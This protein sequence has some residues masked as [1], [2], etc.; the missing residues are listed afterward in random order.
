MKRQ[1]AYYGACTDQLKLQFIGRFPSASSHCNDKLLTSCSTLRPQYPGDCPSSN[2][3]FPL[4]SVSCFV[5]AIPE[6][7]SPYDFRILPLGEPGELVVGGYQLASGYLNRPEQT[8]AAFIDTPYGPVYRTGDKATMKPDGTIECLG[9]ISDGQVKLRGQRIELGEVEQAAMRTEGCHSAIAMV[10]GGILVAFCAFDDDSKSEDQAEDVI[11]TCRKWLPS[12]MVPGNVVIKT[13]FPRLPSGKVDRKQLKSDYAISTTPTESHSTAHPETSNPLEREISA[14]VSDCLGFQVSLSA[15]LASSG[16]DSLKAIRLASALWERGFQTSATDVL[17]SKTLSALC[18]TLQAEKSSSTPSQEDAPIS[19]AD[20]A[21]IQISQVLEKH[22]HLALL[23][24]EIERLFWCTPLQNSMLAETSVNPQA[25]C[26]WIELEFPPDITTQ[27]IEKWTHQIAENNCILRSGFVSFGRGF[28]HVTFRQLSQSAIQTVDQFDHGFQLVSDEDYLRPLRVQ[29]RDGKQSKGP[30]ALFQLHHAIYDGWSVDMLVEDFSALA[31]GRSP[32]SRPQYQDVARF[33]TDTTTQNWMDEARSFWADHLLGWQRHNLPRLMGRP[34]KS[35]GVQTN[36]KKLNISQSLLDETAQKFSCHPQVLFQAGLLW[37][38]A[39]VQGQTDVVIGS[40]SSG[41]T[42]PVT[43]IERTM[44][45]CITTTP[46][47]INLTALTSIAD[48]VR[49]IHST[50]RQV[51]QHGILPLTDI[52]KIAGVNPGEALFDVLFVYQESLYSQQPQPGK[53]RE[54]SHQDYLETSL[55]VE[56][57]PSSEGPVC[58][59]TYHTDAISTEHADLLAEQLESVVLHLL[60]QPHSHI[61]TVGE[62]FAPELKSVYNTNPSNLSTIPDLAATFEQSAS[63]TPY[64]TAIQ[65]ANALQHEA[66]DTISYGDLNSL[67]NKIARWLREH[68]ASEGGIVGLIMEKSINLYAAMLGILKAGCAYLPLLPTTP[69]ERTQGIL[70]QAE[71][72]ICVADVEISA[73]LGDLANCIFMD[74]PSID[75]SSNMDENMCLPSNP[76]RPAYVIY[77]SGTTGTPKGVVVTQENIVSNLDVLSRI[78]PHSNGSRFLQ[79]CSQAFDVS[80]FEIFFTWKVGACLCSGSN[81][82][83]FEDLEEA[84]R[85]LECT[86]LSLTPTVASLIDPR[87]VPNVEFLVTA[88]EPM[89]AVVANKWTGYLYQGK[90]PIWLCNCFR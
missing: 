23:Q 74:I 25:Y 18:T 64:A 47:R 67:A 14:I 17:R 81:D 43:N 31:A 26:N 68:G 10:I 50:N 82:T 52:K 80:V 85:F 57:E 7:G 87:N 88:G 42:I 20:S 13:S 66:V 21:E 71:I 15:H 4:D 53:V 62:S 5:T 24:S 59:L 78:Y 35:R 12:F 54:I 3:G 2:I 38:W 75:M 55:L 83:L 37:L 36:I 58:R 51:L 69:T 90:F 1:K 34:P 79:A 19:G 33:Y 56:I 22:E 73:A 40:V 86:H 44:G 30:V 48:I 63:A 39:H 61:N 8:S 65:F 29:L 32:Q 84:I 77:T 45:P 46:L 6:E 70:T 89:T 49:D 60:R 76:S 11:N 9:R 41:R 28:A 27:E 16:I 72:K